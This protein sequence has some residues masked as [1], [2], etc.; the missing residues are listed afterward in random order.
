MAD[1]AASLGTTSFLLPPLASDD[2]ADFLAA[3]GCF[4]DPLDLALSYATPPSSLSLSSDF[5]F[6]F[7]LFALSLLSPLP[8]DDSEDGL[9][10]SKCSKILLRGVVDMIAVGLIP[11]RK[12]E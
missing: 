11:V 6:D 10:L 1:P 7:A 2:L 3:D 8:S 12:Y 5:D 9:S 4:F